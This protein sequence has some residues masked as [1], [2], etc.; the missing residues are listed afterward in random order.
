[1]YSLACAVCSAS[2]PVC[3][4]AHAAAA[5]AVAPVAAAAAGVTAAAAAMP[6]TAATAAAAHVVCLLLV[7]PQLAL[8]QVRYEHTEAC[9]ILQHQRMLL[10]DVI[11]TCTVSHINSAVQWLTAVHDRNLEGPGLLQHQGMLF[12]GVIHTWARS[13]SSS[14]AQCSQWLT[15]SL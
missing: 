14:A 13:Q 11:H 4:P 15:T 1:M 6:T 5:A 2:K 3:M 10:D 7:H 9:G 8:V 12:D